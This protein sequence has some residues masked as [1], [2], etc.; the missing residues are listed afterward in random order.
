MGEGGIALFESYLFII[1]LLTFIVSCVEIFQVN[2]GDASGYPFGWEGG[3][4]AYA[5]SSNY[6]LWS[7]LTAFIICSYMISFLVRRKY[8]R[9]FSGALLVSIILFASDWEMLQIIFIALRTGDPY[10]WMVWGAPL[11]ISCGILFGKH[12]YRGLFPKRQTAA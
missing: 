3:G 10:C 12:L 1:C 2:F 9:L 5:S 6:T 8:P 11:L 4:W 7:A